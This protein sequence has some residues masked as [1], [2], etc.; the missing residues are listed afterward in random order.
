MVCRGGRLEHFLLPVGSLAHRLNLCFCESRFRQ[1]VGVYQVDVV[2]PGPLLRIHKVEPL[3]LVLHTALDIVLDLGLAGLSLLGGDQDYTVCSTAT[4][5]GRCRCILEDFEGFD[6]VSVDGGGAGRNTVDDVQRVITTL[7]GVD[8]TD[9]DGIVTFR[10]TGV[11]R[12]HD[13][14]NTSLKGVNRIGYRIGGKFFRL[15]MRDRTGEVATA[16]RTVTDDN[17]ILK[18]LDIVLEDDIDR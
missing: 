8:T 11:L 3:D 4:V 14:R 15:D 16:H 7:D 1:C 18:S 6:V 10:A 9:T 2:E 5:D 17:C 12:N 13:S